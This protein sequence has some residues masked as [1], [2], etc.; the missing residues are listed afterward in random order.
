VL[1]PDGC[2]YGLV[3]AVTECVGEP[4]S[5]VAHRCCLGSSVR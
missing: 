5:G 4:L 1:T 3:D 2:L